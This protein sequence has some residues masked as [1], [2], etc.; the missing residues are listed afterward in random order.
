M[1]TPVIDKTALPEPDPT[2]SI[3]IHTGAGGVVLH[4]EALGP[5][6]EIG[7]QLAELGARLQR[8][9]KEGR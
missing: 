3:D 4:V 9:A 1:R 5:K 6:A 8:E 7:R 2:H